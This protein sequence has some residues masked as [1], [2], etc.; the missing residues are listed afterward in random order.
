MHLGSKIFEL[1]KKVVSTQAFYEN[2]IQKQH[3]FITDN[4]GDAFNGL[5]GWLVG[6]D[7]LK[8]LKGTEATSSTNGGNIKKETVED[9]KS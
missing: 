2:F 8:D 1:A 9:N 3:E 6:G 7:L 4:R 5:P